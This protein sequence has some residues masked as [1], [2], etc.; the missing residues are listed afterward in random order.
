MADADNTT[1]LVVA[2]AVVVV[3][4]MWSRKAAAAPMSGG[5]GATM[6]PPNG[7][8]ATNLG[9]ILQG[10]GSLFS[11]LSDLAGAVFKS[12]EESTYTVP[13][14]ERPYFNPFQDCGGPGQ[15]TC[16]ELEARESVNEILG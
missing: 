12:D 14:T 4:V 15:I 16:E 7:S 9:G 8:A 6:L 13:S 11:G 5:G 10:A 2:A 1:V 3:A